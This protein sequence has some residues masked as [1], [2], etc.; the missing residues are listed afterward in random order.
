VADGG[1][2]GMTLI[3]TSGRPL[4]PRA[5]Y[6]AARISRRTTGW[7][8]AGT[9]PNA[10]IARD[11]GTLRNRHRDLARNSPWV[12][13]AIQA[14]V[15]N[16]IGPGIRA[17]WKHADGSDDL[18]RQARWERWWETTACDADGRANGYGLQALVMRA[19]VESGAA[20]IRRRPRSTS[21]DA[22]EIPLQLQ[23]L[24]P[25]YIDTTKNESITGGGYI[26]QGVEFGPFGRRQAYWLLSDHPGDPRPGASGSTS[27]RYLAS[28]FAHIFRVDR[29]GQV[30][31]VPWG[32]GAML[33]ARMLDDYQD[34]QLERQRLAAC[35]MAF[36]RPSLDG[37]PMSAD[38]YVFSDKI[39]PGIIEDLPPGYDMSFASPPQPENDK[40][41]QLAILRAVAAD[42]GIPY[43]VMTGDLSEVNFSSARM[44]W[45]EFSRNI[46]AWRWQMIAPQMLSLIERWYLEA[47]AVAGFGTDGARPLWTAPSRTMVDKTREIKPLIEEI[48]AGLISLPEAI[49]QVG[50]DPLTLAREQAEFIAVLDGLGLKASSVPNHDANQQATDTQEAPNADE[51]NP[52]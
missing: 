38:E 39:E 29:P 14:L 46:S 10:E 50:Y 33:R 8:A 5:Q 16:T 35:F 40:D 51:T 13:R 43:E 15:T 4:R 52:H 25:D 32:T 37:E 17:Q 42:Y 49:R 2:P 36:R 6:D 31:G 41:F 34:A 20:L 21:R 45:N 30:H 12:R 24:E 48:R 7:L 47:E 28:E 9:G 18:E 11:L 26:R 22:L 27:K 44:G 19:V 3:D 23:V 1:A